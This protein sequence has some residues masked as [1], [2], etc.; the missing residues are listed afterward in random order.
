MKS[1]LSLIFTGFLLS[2]APL[3]QGAYEEALYYVGM[4]CNHIQKDSLTDPDNE[5]FIKTIITT[6]DNSGP[7]IQH[8]LPGNGQLYKKVKNGFVIQQ[9]KKRLWQGRSKALSL[10]VSLW[11]SDDG[12]QAI[13]ALSKGLSAA[14]QYA[15]AARSASSAKPTPPKQSRI[16]EDR[17]PDPLAGFFQKGFG[18]LGTRVDLL[19]DQRVAL[20]GGGWSNNTLKTTHN[21]HYHFST[22]HRQQ[23]A[24]CRVYFLF[25]RGPEYNTRPL[26]NKQTE[27][28]NQ[29][30]TQKRPFGP[31]QA[32]CRQE[33]E[34]CYDQIN[35]CHGSAQKKYNQC[36]AGLNKKLQACND[37]HHRNEPIHSTRKSR[38]NSRDTHPKCTRYLKT[39]NYCGSSKSAS[40]SAYSTCDNQNRRCVQ[41]IPKHPG[42]IS[43]PP[44]TWNNPGTQRTER[45][46]PTL[47]YIKNLCNRDTSIAYHY[48]SLKGNWITGGWQNLSP[49]ERQ[50][51]NLSTRHPLIYFHATV[52]RLNNR[53]F[54]EP[55]KRLAVINPPFKHSS[56]QKLSGSGYR[57]KAF[58]PLRYSP[59][60]QR[61]TAYIDCPN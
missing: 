4:S 25:K 11:E 19:G 52:G 6:L 39:A 42:A 60:K 29:P 9:P 2:F 43:T 21:I 14:I 7:V 51:P 57:V 54:T 15:A 46:E 23:G 48:R 50:L 36:V 24:D 16:T 59:S 18:K 61:V 8:T 3:V 13:S 37:W 27:K 5:L 56:D 45:N 44:P 47:V 10:H 20:T 17:S 41:S 32:E 53:E 12:K 40:C 31:S 33:Y 30:P 28:P 22:R 38:S 34:A 49:G 1:H 55:L 58:Y 35:Q 26:S